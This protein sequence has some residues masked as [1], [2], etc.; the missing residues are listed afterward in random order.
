VVVTNS[1]PGSATAVALTDQLSTS[2]RFVSA[3]STS[4]S[5]VHSEG[6]VTCEIGTVASGD[7]ATVTVVVSARRTGTATNIAEVGSVSP[8]ANQA[9]NTDI[10]ETVITR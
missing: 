5:C 8:D 6:T 4:G 3:A 7:S 1:G 9:N 2:V 10:E